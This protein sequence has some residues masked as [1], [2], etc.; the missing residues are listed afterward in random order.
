M[1]LNFHELYEENT[2]NKIYQESEL[3]DLINNCLKTLLSEQVDE[4]D[5][6]KFDEYK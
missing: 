5:G 1:D 2:S 6:E 3:P 4:E